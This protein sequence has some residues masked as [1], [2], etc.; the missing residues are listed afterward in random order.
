MRYNEETLA[1]L[2]GLLYAG[3]S[4]SSRMPEFL[5]RM[6]EASNA[7]TGV[8]QF[9]D[10][11]HARGQVAL[12]VGAIAMGSD[13]ADAY[14][15]RFVGENVWVQYGAELLIRNGVVTGTEI[16]D[17]RALQ[18]TSFYQDFLRPLDIHDSIAALL[19]N[20][21]ASGFAMLTLNCS[22]AQG[23]FG[24]SEKTL[25]R[26]LLPHL[27]NAYALQ[28]RLSWVDDQLSSVRGALD[29]L[30]FGVLM[31]DPKGLLRVANEMAGEMLGGQLTLGTAAARLHGL[32]ASGRTA[33]N[34]AVTAAL[35]DRSA[36]P[37]RTRVLL[38]TSRERGVG[39]VAVVIPVPHSVFADFDIGRAKVVVFLHALEART[40]S[41]ESDRWL[42]DMYGLSPVQARLT[43]MICDGLDLDQCAA[44]LNNTKH[45]VRTQ[46]KLVYAKT[47]CI[48][49]P[50]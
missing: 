46:L 29:R 3:V 13:E 31:F 27:Q 8:I 12:S 7:H 4:D 16:I 49:R 38:R 24:E 14:K 22:N 44:A 37:V 5:G 35:A 23:T 2:I 34:S 30:C 43:R 6:A 25:L 15:D 28:R 32:D 19:W 17:P 11:G 40:C 21:G 18:Q 48:V 39:I 1:N 20:G 26:R 45:T 41:E 36:A 47:G 33:L 9:E 10:T 50:N 42:S